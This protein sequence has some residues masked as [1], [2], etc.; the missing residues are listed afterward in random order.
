MF[1][2][3]MRSSNQSTGDPENWN[4]HATNYVARLTLGGIDSP[5]T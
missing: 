1:T 2:R 5:G 3:H 4:E